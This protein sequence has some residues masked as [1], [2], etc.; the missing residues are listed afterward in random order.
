MKAVRVADIL[1][2]RYAIGDEVRIQ[3]W[4][5]TRRDSKV[6][7]SFVHVSDGSGFDPLQVVADG[8]LENYEGEVLRLTS[9]CAVDIQGELQESK[10]KG[11]SLELRAVSIANAY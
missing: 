9:G 7:F 8:T 5:R 6:G 2:G 10:G 4:V 3:G 11:Q 1:A